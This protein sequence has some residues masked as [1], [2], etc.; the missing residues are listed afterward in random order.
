MRLA[1]DK[2]PMGII[3]ASGGVNAAMLCYR[4]VQARKEHGVALLTEGGSRVQHSADVCCT[5]DLPLMGTR[6]T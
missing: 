6:N 2:P 5:W 4:V 1:S 3:A